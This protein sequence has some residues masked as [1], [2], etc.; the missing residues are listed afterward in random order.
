[1]KTLLSED[2]EMSQKLLQAIYSK[3]AQD[4]APLRFSL[5]EQEGEEIEAAEE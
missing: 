2:A 5:S 3:L 1:V 4:G